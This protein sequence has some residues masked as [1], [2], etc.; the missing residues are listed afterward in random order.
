MEKDSTTVQ[1]DGE[2]VLTASGSRDFGE[3]T[4]EIAQLIGRQAGKIRLRIGCHSN[5]NCNCN[6]N[7]GEM[8]IERTGRLKQIQNAGFKNARD[9]VEFVGRNYNAIYKGGGRSLKIS[10]RSERDC[11][12]FI[13]LEPN[14]EEDFYDVKTAMITR[15]TY[16]EKETPLWT[17][18]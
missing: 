11:T 2:Y 15:K 5:N 8:H 14:S 12:M 10:V 13:Q 7:Y 16:L 4:T 3:I 1:H 9:F 18:P 6:E 17:N